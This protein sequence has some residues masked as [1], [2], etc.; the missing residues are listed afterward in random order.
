M[1]KYIVHKP[2]APD[3]VKKKQQ[4]T[5]EEYAATFEGQPKYDGC[6]AIMR[7]ETAEVFSRT[8]EVNIALNG[9]AV[10]ILNA[11]ISRDLVLIGEAWNPSMPFSDISGEFRRHAVSDR[12]RFVINDVLT[13]QE[14]D[15]GHSPV[16][17]RERAERLSE[18]DLKALPVR[19]YF[20]SR[21]APGSYGM[22]PQKLCGRFVNMGRYD[23]LIMRDPWGLWSV[24]TGT[25]GEVVKLK[26]R[27]SYDL[28]VIDWEPGKGKHAGRAGALIV[29]FGGKR[30]G[31]GTGLT[32]SQRENIANN[33]R[34]DWRGKIVEVE[35]MDL[36]SEGLLREPRF[37]GIRHDKLEADAA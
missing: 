1:S 34:D 35:A 18:A 16:P 30:L 27:L 22:D 20:T 9:L 12:L 23:G 7:L 10:D 19:A 15:A 33:F 25:G 11:G 24:G 8:G 5:L 31:V 29:D 3:K 14:F 6:C 36:S 2:V 4:R 21:F 13:V 17:Y 32:D 26:K 28:R 37:K